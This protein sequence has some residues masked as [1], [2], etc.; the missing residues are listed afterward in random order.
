MTPPTID[1][2]TETT[3]HIVYHDK[4]EALRQVITLLD[5]LGLLAGVGMMYGAGVNDR[6]FIQ[7]KGV[8]HAAIFGV[9]D[10]R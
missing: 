7:P 4:H 2:R 8:D 6:P 3:L 10:G 1:H 5:S 9:R